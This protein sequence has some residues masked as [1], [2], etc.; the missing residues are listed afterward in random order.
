MIQ[1]NI[2]STLRYKLIFYLLSFEKN[3]FILVAM[4][5]IHVQKVSEY[6]QEMPPLH[7][8]DQPMAS[9]G[10]QRMITAT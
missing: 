8:T 4:N 1:A 6:G 3:A 10:S 7:T 2:L 9:R 5:E